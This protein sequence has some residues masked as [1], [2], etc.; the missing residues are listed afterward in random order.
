MDGQNDLCFSGVVLCSGN[1][2]VLVLLSFRREKGC[3]LFI[4]QLI[5]YCCVF[6]MEGWVVVTFFVPIYLEDIPIDFCNTGVN[7]TRTCPHDITWI[8][9]HCRQCIGRCMQ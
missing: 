2:V 6:R 9:F 1:F 4:E 5:L 3:P 8:G 7:S